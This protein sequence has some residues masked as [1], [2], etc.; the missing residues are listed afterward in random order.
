MQSTS[1]HPP[2]TLTLK[3]LGRL[4]VRVWPYVRPQRK[5]IIAWI[6]L[7]V[8]ISVLMMISFL[9]IFDLF[10]NK[11]LIGDPLDSVQAAALLLDSGYTDAETESLTQE[12]RRTVRNRFIVSVLF[13]AISVMLLGQQVV[14]PYYETWIVQRINQHLR[15]T[16]IEK[17][18]HLSLRYHNQARTGDAIY[19]VFQDSAMIT[20]I[21]SYCVFLP[22]QYGFGLLFGTLI[23]WIFSPILGLLCLVASIPV[24]LLVVWY[25]PRIQRRAWTAR[26]A[27]SNLTSRIQEA[28]A[29]IRVIKASQSEDIVMDRF[30]R[31]S[32]LALDTAFMLRLEILVMR[33]AVVFVVGAVM[34]SSYLLMAQWT[35]LE[36]PT[37]LAG[38]FAFLGFA[39]WNFGAYYASRDRTEASID[40]WQLL[41]GLW[42]ISQD[43]AMGLDRAFY[44]LDLEPGVVDAEN[45][46]AMPAP[47]REVTYSNVHFA[48]EED[49][50]VLRGVDLRAAA[51]TV[52]AIVGAT[53]S[54]K[55]TL[56]SLLLRLYD[57]GEGSM[58]VNGTDLKDIWVAD[59]RSSTAIALQQNVLFATTIAENIAYATKGA[60]REAVEA[61]AKIACADT[62]IGEMEKGYDTE[63]GERGGKLST[64]Q[65]QR[66]TLARAIIRDTPILILDE[67][68]ASLD[69]E[70]EQKVLANLAQWGRERVLFLITHRLSTIR[71][72]DQIAFLED[73]RIVEI[74]SHEELIAIPGGRYRNFVAAESEGAQPEEETPS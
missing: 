37:F 67:P 72:A 58:A 22:I 30:E 23:V 25:T 8:A 56:M 40:G 19:R 4:F 31:D 66:L 3:E 60:S 45:A 68:T 53:G 41:I 5:H 11:I 44:L 24:I 46:V 73:G 32:T 14:L 10:S 52:T 1:P 12:Q 54:G 47:I 17:A 42:N 74:G 34:I 39:A 63:L 61:A 7:G 38:A 33:T 64:G 16:M 9:A 13:L 26:Q 27:N 29:A 57:P 48:Y 21:I 69:A 50:P 2:A 28:A 15:V 35:I 43:M 18:E 49:R 51:G 20:Q 62:F 59:V 70:T 55:S 6:C 65:R 71:N 36:K